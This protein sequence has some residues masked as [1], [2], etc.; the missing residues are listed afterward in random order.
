MKTGSETS[1][2]LKVVSVIPNV[3]SLLAVI[4][5]SPDKVTHLEPKIELIVKY[6]YFSVLIISMRC[7]EQHTKSPK[8]PGSGNMFNSYQSK[9]SD[10]ARQQ[11]TAMGLFFTFTPIKIK[12]YVMKVSMISKEVSWKNLFKYANELNS[13][14]N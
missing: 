8:N 1:W 14:P 12:L 9:M 2:F 4:L 3:L 5:N 11:S 10:K 6:L 13:R 7:P